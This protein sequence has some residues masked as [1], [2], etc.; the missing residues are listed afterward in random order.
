MQCPVRGAGTS[1]I[2]N[3]FTMFLRWETLKYHSSVPGKTSVNDQFHVD[4]YYTDKHFHHLVQIHCSFHGFHQEKA[5]ASNIYQS[6]QNTL[7]Y[8]RFNLLLCGVFDQLARK[9][10]KL[11]IS[12]SL[13]FRYLC[14]QFK[15]VDEVMLVSCL[16]YWLTVNCN[17]PR[18]TA[19]TQGRQ[20]RRRLS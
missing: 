2:S 11:L 10:W 16:F 14:L 8:K 6:I 19:N 18:S 7:Q 4:N 5:L 3:M 17:E 20:E 9:A 1:K 12:G 13:L 15:H